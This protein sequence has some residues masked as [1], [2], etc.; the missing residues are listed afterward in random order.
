M[1]IGQVTVSPSPI[2]TV[3]EGNNLTF[4][5]SG[6]TVGPKV[7]QVN[8]NISTATTGRITV[9][10]NTEGSGSAIDDTST[11]YQFTALT[12]ADNG[13][14]VQCFSNGIGS[15][16]LTVIVDCKYIVYYSNY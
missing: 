7:L 14:T 3:L 5:C 6:S 9:T 16:I 8:S 2:A 13:T 12:R 11:Y 10:S 1:Y 4:T 15:N